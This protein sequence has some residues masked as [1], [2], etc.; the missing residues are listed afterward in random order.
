[1][2]L[3]VS[4]RSRSGL[5]R[6]PVDSPAAHSPVSCGEEP[7]RSGESPGGLPT[8]LLAADAHLPFSAQNSL[9]A[10]AQSISQ[11]FAG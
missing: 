10:V 6:V 8:L 2:L 11:K 1:M 5:M 4:E 3:K 7:L 9:E